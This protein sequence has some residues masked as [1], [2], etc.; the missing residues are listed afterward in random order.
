MTRR[1]IDRAGPSDLGQRIRQLLL[2]K[3]IRIESSCCTLIGLISFQGNGSPCNDPLD[4]SPVGLYEESSTS[5]HTPHLMANM[6]T[7][8]PDLS[9]TCKP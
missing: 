1:I 8:N 9:G 3:P 2:L 6:N 4:E 5:H 7:L